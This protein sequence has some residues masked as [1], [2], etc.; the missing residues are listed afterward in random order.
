ML[1]EQVRPEKGVLARETEGKGWMKPTFAF[2]FLLQIRGFRCN[3]VENGGNRSNRK[4]EPKS[5]RNEILSN[6]GIIEG[7]K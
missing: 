1:S 2:P 6:R 4:A 3:Y 7:T 5:G